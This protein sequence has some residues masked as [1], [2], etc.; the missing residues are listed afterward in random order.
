M[1][2]ETLPNWFWIIHHAFM[3]SAFV[4]AIH[5]LHRIRN[6]IYSI[7]TLF[8]TI[9]VPIL[10]VLNSIER[11]IGLNEFEHLIIELQQ[12]SIWSI[13]IGIGY[14]YILVWWVLFFATNKNNK[15]P[16]TSGTAP[17]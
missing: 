8:F 16:H 12:G 3:F 13:Y 6:I 11:E 17:F 2:W 9:T 15:P 7:I 14:L 4:T 10:S 1:Y 5:S